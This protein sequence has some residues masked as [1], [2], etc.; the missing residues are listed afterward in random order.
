MRVLNNNAVLVKQRKSRSK[1]N[2]VADSE[3]VRGNCNM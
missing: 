2:I 1:A 3:S